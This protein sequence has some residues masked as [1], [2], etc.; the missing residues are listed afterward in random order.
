[1]LPI[2]EESFNQNSNNHGCNCENTG[3]CSLSNKYL[4]ADIVYKAVI[5]AP[6]QPDNIYFGIA[7]ITFNNRFRNDRRSTLTALNI[8]NTCGEV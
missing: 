5:S 8:L 2:I 4:T 6:I 1:M 3:E 7:E